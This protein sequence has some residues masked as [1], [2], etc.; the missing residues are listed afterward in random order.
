VSEKTDISDVKSYYGSRVVGDSS[1]EVITMLLDE[2]ADVL[3]QMPTQRILA[4][5][6]CMLFGIALVSTA[7][8]AEPEA[9][10]GE[11]MRYG[12]ASGTLRNRGFGI[13]LLLSPL[14]VTL[15]ALIQ[16][17]NATS[18]LH[19][20]IVSTLQTAVAVLVSVLFSNDDAVKRSPN[21][22]AHRRHLLISIAIGVVIG[23]LSTAAWKAWAWTS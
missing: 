21:G 4:G 11:G 23:V 7:S 14:A 15:L 16:L 19:P 9:K 6:C 17:F 2:I 10:E 5:V 22:P 3:S 20:A 8:H 1:L 18:G 12:P 13:G